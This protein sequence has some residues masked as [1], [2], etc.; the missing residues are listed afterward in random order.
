MTK[1]TTATARNVMRIDR[2]RKRTAMPYHSRS[3]RETGEAVRP[4]LKKVSMTQAIRSRS[5]LGLS[6][7]KRCTDNA[8]EGMVVTVTV[9][10]L[11][12]AHALVEE[13]AAIGADSHVEE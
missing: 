12:D 13:L 5:G 8:L 3:R 7:G 9:P 10:T 11:A 1:Q 4:G 2:R 6:Q